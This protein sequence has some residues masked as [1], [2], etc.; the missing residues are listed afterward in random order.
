MKKTFVTK[1]LYRDLV[2]KRVQSEMR[3]LKTRTKLAKA[4]KDYDVL[5]TVKT[6]WY[7]SR[8]SKKFMRRMGTRL[9]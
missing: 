3:V 2:K 9:R 8:P 4:K 6:E 7:G 5:L 1:K